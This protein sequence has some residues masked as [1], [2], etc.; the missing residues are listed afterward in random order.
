M[1]ESITLPQIKFTKPILI[2][3]AGLLILGGLFGAGYFIGSS[4]RT[5]TLTTALKTQEQTIQADKATLATQVA[6]IPTA[7]A[8]AQSAR[9]QALTVRAKVEAQATPTALPG[10]QTVEK[11]DDAALA[12][13]TQVTTETQNAL[14]TAQKTIQDGDSEVTTLKALAVIHPNALGVTYGGSECY[15][16]W[17]SRTFLHRVVL[18]VEVDQVKYSGGATTIVANAKVGWSW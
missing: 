15:G 18:G 4:K 7:Q 8:T 11:S 13:Q 3:L 9:A 17:Y 1:F 16:V 6:A 5:L 12:A 10:I 14:N 2:G